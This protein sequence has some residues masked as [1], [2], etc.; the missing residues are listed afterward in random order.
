MFVRMMGKHEGYQTRA[1]LGGLSGDSLSRAQFG[2]PQAWLHWRARFWDQ[3]RSA[4]DE[5]GP[6][7][8][9]LAPRAYPERNACWMCL[10]L[11]HS[12]VQRSGSFLSLKTVLVSGALLVVAMEEGLLAFTCR[13]SESAGGA[14]LRGSS[15]YRKD[16]GRE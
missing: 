5:W 13:Q 15:E 9:S 6:R 2:R 11:L 14:N 1:T 3:R 7:P 4:W 16:Q 10:D 8:I 12:R